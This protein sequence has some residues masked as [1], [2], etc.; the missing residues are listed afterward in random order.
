M[1]RS[2]RVEF[3]QLAAEA[4]T[5]A[6]GEAIYLEPSGPQLI[7]SVAGPDLVLWA[8]TQLS[9][10]ECR[11]RLEAEGLEV[12]AGCWISDAEA[13]AMERWARP[14]IV[15]VA[16]SSAKGR[17]G[18]WV[19]A[20]AEEPTQADV[21]RAMYEEFRETGDV[22]DVTMEEFIRAANPNVVILSPEEVRRYAERKP[23]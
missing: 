22:A 20:T 10:E 1:Q 19:D 4:R 9:H 11:S 6:P 23:C 21:L 14:W 13:L 16:Y 7:V 17:P 8:I 12:R 5:R 18:L 2:L 15:A 3:D